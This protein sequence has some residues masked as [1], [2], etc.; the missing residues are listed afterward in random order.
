LNGALYGAKRAEND[1]SLIVAWRRYGTQVA[2]GFH[3]DGTC[4][5]TSGPTASPI[6]RDR[7]P[8]ATQADAS[9]SSW[10]EGILAFTAALRER[11]LA[12]D[13]VF[14]KKYLK[15]LVEEIRYQTRQLVM[16][17][18]DA[19]VARVAGES[20]VGTPHGPVPTFDL[21]WL[22]AQDSNFPKWGS[23]L[24][25]PAQNQLILDIGHLARLTR[26]QTFE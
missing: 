3:V 7:W 4:E 19:A 14:S 5:P 8:A 9:G 26:V 15:L 25:W 21:D 18:S 23:F 11:L 1:T 20:K 2:D 13:R 22:P 16:K 6:D 12:K 24:T 17:G 10:R